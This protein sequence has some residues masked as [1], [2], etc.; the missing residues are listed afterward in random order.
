MGFR[1]WV[2]RVLVEMMQDGSDHSSLLTECIVP[3]YKSLIV[4]LQTSSTSKV[5]LLMRSVLVPS[6]EKLSVLFTVDM[7]AGRGH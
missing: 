7:S 3:A 5:W 6:K 1:F 2:M 4:A